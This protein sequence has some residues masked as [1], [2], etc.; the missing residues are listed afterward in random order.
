MA[1]RL[2]NKLWPG[3]VALSFAVDAD[4]RAEAA[5][6]LKCDE[7]L[8]YA[9]DGRITLR[10]PDE[11]VTR[12]VLAAA[13][14]PVVLTR[15]GLPRGSDASRPPTADA[16]PAGVTTLLLA[17]PTR[18][19]RPSTVVR[20]D[21]EEWTVVR[22]GVFDR[23]IL[24]KLLRTTVLFVC[25]GNTCRSPMAMAL[26]RKELADA[27]GVPL[28][29][30]GDSGY[31]VV[32]AGTFAMPG[33]K[34]TPQAADAVADMG[35]EL[36]GHRS[37]PLTV[38]LVHRADLIVTM[39]RDH[40]EGVVASCRRRRGRPSRSTPTATSRTPSAPTRNIT[41]AWPARSARSCA[42]G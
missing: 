9:D 36:A 18:Y 12:E 7:K 8:L 32:S 37:Q 13:G 28:A 4:R 40:S 11:P 6:A 1:R 27:A 25:S 24:E 22:E 5:G 14:Q 21:G 41:E 30:L 26:A 42:T 34:A 33:M 19:N 3:P 20:V 29:K 35:G 15:S 10:C 23:R 16:L 31:E 17:G 39:G 38:E 2:M